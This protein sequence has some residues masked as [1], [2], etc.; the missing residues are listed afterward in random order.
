MKKLVILFVSV[1]VFA[2]C[3]KEDDFE[4]NDI[5]GVWEAKVNSEYFP[6][7]SFIYYFFS[8]DGRFDTWRNSFSTINNAMIGKN[9][10]RQK[11]TFK[12]ID[13]FIYFTPDIA[14]VAAE[15]RGVPI[16]TF[17]EIYPFN[18]IRPT[19]IKIDNAVY[20]KKE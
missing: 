5:F 15:R 10:N 3:N 2:S 17:V 14:E 8:E 20:T 4:Y 19:K 13:G 18:E 1:L 11:G 6:E 16:S 7:Y 12:I 9:F